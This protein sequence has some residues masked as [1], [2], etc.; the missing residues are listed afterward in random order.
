MKGRAREG[1]GKGPQIKRGR[2]ESGFWG[3]NKTRWNGSPYNSFRKRGR[4]IM[5][6]N[7]LTKRKKGKNKNVKTVEIF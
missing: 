1:N 7:S 5:G 2:Q 4:R 3:A 6:S